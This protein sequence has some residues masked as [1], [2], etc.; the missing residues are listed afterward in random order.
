M[1]SIAECVPQD[2]LDCYY[3]REWLNNQKSNKRVVNN[4]TII[5]DK[6][7]NDF[8][9]M[10]TKAKRN[11]NYILDNLITLRDSYGHR[12]DAS[13][14]FRDLI[15]TVQKINNTLDLAKCVRKFMEIRIYPF[16]GIDIIPNYKDPSVYTLSISE[17]YLSFDA[18][19]SYEKGSEDLSELETTLTKI[20]PFIKNKWGYHGSNQNLFVRNIIVLEILFSYLILTPL[21][22]SEPKVIHN[23]MSFQDFLTIYDTNDF[24]KIIFSGYLQPH[25][26]IS[27]SNRKFV[28]FFKNYLSQIDD[29]DIID[30]GIIS[31]CAFEQ[32]YNNN[33]HDVTKWLCSLYHNESTY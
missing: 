28:A 2:D 19:S 7:D 6:I 14:V 30:I 25:N 32:S 5:Q 15:K 3:N 13:P 27:Y 1:K 33:N 23:S 10:I 29:N 20:Y 11:N 22:S 16:F 8:Y 17:P 24:Y 31:D 12:N 21:E 4:F 26:I 18:K 9:D